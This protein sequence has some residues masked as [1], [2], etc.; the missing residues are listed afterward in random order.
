MTHWDTPQFSAG[1]DAVAGA[2][3]YLTP[4]PEGCD[5]VLLCELTGLF[6]AVVENDEAPEDR[7]DFEVDDVAVGEDDDVDDEFVSIK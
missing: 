4:E 5:D 7:T 3:L 1:F 6:A 2:E